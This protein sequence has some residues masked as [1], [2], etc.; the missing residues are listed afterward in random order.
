[1]QW[2]RDHQ[3][4]AEELATTKRSLEST[5]TEREALARQLKVTPFP[6]PFFRDTV[7]YLHYEPIVLVCF[8][9]PLFLS[10]TYR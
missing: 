4:C 8:P 3:R 6:P 1:M 2:E 7:S 10:C 5:Q 9:I